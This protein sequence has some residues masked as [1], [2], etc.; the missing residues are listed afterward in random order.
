MAQGR[1]CTQH[2]VRRRGGGG[3]DAVRHGR[4]L[5][6]FYNN[7]LKSFAKSGRL[8]VR[9]LLLFVCFLWS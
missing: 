2:R 4:I 1:A 7:F 6:G 5:Q 3:A 9:R 8:Q